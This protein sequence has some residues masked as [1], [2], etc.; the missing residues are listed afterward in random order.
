MIIG[1]LHHRTGPTHE[2]VKGAKAT[3]APCPPAQPN[4]D[5][6]SPCRTSDCKTLKAMSQGR[7]S[8]AKDRGEGQGRRSRAKDRGERQGR[9]SKSKAKFKVRVRA[10]KS[11]AN[12]NLTPYFLAALVAHA[13][14]GLGPFNPNLGTRAWAHLPL[15]GRLN[16]EIPGIKSPREVRPR[17]Q[18]GTPAPYSAR[19]FPNHH[20]VQ[21]SHHRRGVFQVAS[22]IL[23]QAGPHCLCG[24][25][26]YGDIA[27]PPVTV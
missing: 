20:P 5:C 19:H 4:P 26:R 3:S 1:S 8:R 10:C 13:P 11:R 21:V 27:R 12:H 16:P 6:V 18:P 14:N 22:I 9:K 25:V 23:V 2:R 24:L 15:R 7:R 17:S